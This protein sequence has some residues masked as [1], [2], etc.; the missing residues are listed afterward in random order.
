MNRDYV[1]I[2]WPHFGPYHIARFNALRSV[3]GEAGFEILGIEI[4][5]KQNKYRW[6]D[7][8]IK[9]QGIITLF[10]DQAI[11]NIPFFSKISRILSILKIYNPKVIITN[12]YS[13]AESVTYLCWCKLNN[14]PAVLMSESNE[15][16][17]NRKPFLEYVKSFIVSN[18]SCAICGGKN[19]VLYLSKL[20]MRTDRVYIGYDVVDNNYFETG[21]MFSKSHP[22][23]FACLPGLEN[24]DPYFLASARFIKRKNI[25]FLL[26][27]YG[28]YR[29]LCRQ[30]A[31]DPWR[32][33]ILGDGV[34]RD[35]VLKTV[36][37][38]NLPDV[39]FPG[40]RTYNELPA[41]YG[42]ASVFVH[43]AIRD[44]WGLVVNEAMAAGLPVL[45]SNQCGCVPEL[46]HEGL[47]GSI[48]D[49]NDF[50]QLAN[51]MYKCSSGSFDLSIMGRMGNRIIRE[52]SPDRFAQEMIT[53]VHQAIEEQI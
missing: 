38:Q 15:L 40:F 53:A 14:R 26:S 8:K 44:Q 19:H 48:F 13:S 36:I 4:A 46:V 24:R 39:I 45:V 10:P 11:E 32:L 2:S 9:N 30:N 22:V 42:L 1:F 43:P 49:P 34:E 33:I 31:A 47:N 37:A 52:W 28:H 7:N 27:A 41:Y 12:G 17:S 51:I 25:P 50:V 21:A 29:E 5:G 16:D 20:G 23:D 3:F 18:Y 35:T 6:F